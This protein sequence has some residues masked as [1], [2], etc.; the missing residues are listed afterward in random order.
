MINVICGY[1][2]IGILVSLFL[3]SVALCIWSCKQTR[4]FYMPYSKE[5]QDRLFK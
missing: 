5:A 2:A 3:I 1:V 4:G